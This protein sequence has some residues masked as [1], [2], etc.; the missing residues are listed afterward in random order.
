MHARQTLYF[1]LHSPDPLLHFIWFYLKGFSKF[2]ANLFYMVSFRIARATEKNPRLEKEQLCI[3]TFK[4]KF[5]CTI[6]ACVGRVC[7]HEMGVGLSI[8]QAW[9]WRQEDSFWE[10]V[11]SFH[12]KT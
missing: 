12:F 1:E 4:F 5:E 6:I 8:C 7:V 11:F 2:K 3:K 10:S 9:H